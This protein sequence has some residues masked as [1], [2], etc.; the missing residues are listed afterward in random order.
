MRLKAF[1][2]KHFF[3]NPLKPPND[4]NVISH[5][6]ECKIQWVFITSSLPFQ[7]NLQLESAHK[8]CRSSS[9][10]SFY[11]PTLPSS[12][13]RNLSQSRLLVVFPSFMFL[14]MMK[15]NHNW[16]TFLIYPPSKCSFSDCS[17][18]LFSFCLLNFHFYFP[19][20][21]VFKCLHK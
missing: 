16:V 8:S 5:K 17:A 14:M 7:R 1:Y 10:F 18:F 21:A 4:L 13:I 12:S 11:F 3:Q 19:S 2:F 6:I 20:L 15:N 9:S